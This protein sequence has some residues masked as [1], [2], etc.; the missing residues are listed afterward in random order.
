MPQPSSQPEPTRQALERQL[1][2]DMAEQLASLE[3]DE[4]ASDRLL[5]VDEMLQRAPQ[6]RAPARLA[7]TILARLAQRVQQQSQLADLPPETQK[8]M[9]LYMSASMM[10]MM[11]MMEAA[12]WLVLNARRD[13]ELLG[14][15][16]LRT[17]SWMSLVNNALILLLED[18]ED[19]ARTQ[20]Q[21][22]R[23]T[24]ALTPHMLHSALDQLDDMA[25]SRA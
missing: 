8:L 12:S 25:R 24:L 5:R 2:E 16:M 18:A 14:E 10:A 17:I 1:S 9:M 11:P 19:L 23:A 20:P 13:P 7:A 6:M 3:L 15:A 22:A 4:A 21:L